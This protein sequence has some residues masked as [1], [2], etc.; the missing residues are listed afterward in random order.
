M[1]IS[2]PVITF[3]LDNTLWNVDTVIHKAEAKMR[4]WLAVNAPQSFSQ[5]QP[6]TLMALRKSVARQYPDKIHDLSFMRTQVLFELI[7]QTGAPD[8]Q[9]LQTAQDAFEIFFVARND[10]VFFPGAIDALTHLSKTFTL[11]A[12]TN[13]NADISRAGLQQ[14]FTDALSS[15]DVGCKKPDPAIFN[16][17]LGRHELLADQVIH[18]GDNLV[19]D[20]YGANNVGMRTIWVNLAGAQRQADDATPHAEITH[21]SQLGDAVSQLV[22]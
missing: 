13:G 1:V 21:L 2:R 9:A 12:L 4:A 17:L 14:Y 7:R 20:I 5:Y 19:D 18:V 3:D 8:D 10:V 6:D 11:I 16:A 15:A 22:S